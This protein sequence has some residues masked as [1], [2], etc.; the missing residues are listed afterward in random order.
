MGCSRRRNERRAQGLLDQ[1]IA[2][3]SDRLAQPALDNKLSKHP[4]HAHEHIS[5]DKLATSWHDGDPGYAGA[6]IVDRAHPQR[7]EHLHSFNSA[8]PYLGLSF[9]ENRLEAYSRGKGRPQ[10]TSTALAPFPTMQGPIVLDTMAKHATPR[11]TEPEEDGA[12]HT[13]LANVRRASSNQTPPSSKAKGIISSAEDP[14]KPGIKKQYCDAPVYG[15]EVLTIFVGPEPDPKAFWMHQEL[16]TKLSGLIDDTCQNRTDA[17]ETP[18]INLPRSDP[19]HFELFF[20]FAYTRSIFS[21]KHDDLSDGT[22]DQEWLRLVQAY[23]L[24]DHLHTMDFQDAVVDAILEKINNTRRSL[25][26]MLHRVIYCNIKSNTLLRRLAV[27]IAAWRWDNAFLTAQKTAGGWRGSDACTDFFVDLA[28][29]LNE[30]KNTGQSGQPPFE[31]N[32]CAYHEHRLAGTPC[33][34]TKSRF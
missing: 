28:L 5:A 12:V 17:G 32:T 1:A 34:K 30:T 33:Y 25:P 29:T 2:A 10:P 27:D 16:A 13:Q 22:V 31:G 26:P 18:V 15:G 14:L 4:D 24:G 7:S 11:H 20:L 9:E 8:P 6:L 19:E 21:T 23:A 3:E